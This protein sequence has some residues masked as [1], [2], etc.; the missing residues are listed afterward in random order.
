M[1]LGRLDWPVKKALFAI[2]QMILSEPGHE[3]FS[4]RGAQHIG[5]SGLTFRSGDG[6]LVSDRTNESLW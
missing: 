5:G 4:P 6:W 3:G 1:G 2:L